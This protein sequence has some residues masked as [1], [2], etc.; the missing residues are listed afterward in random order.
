MSL[1]RRAP[2]RLASVAEVQ[3]SMEFALEVNLHSCLPLP[4]I[5]SYLNLAEMCELTGKHHLNLKKCKYIFLTFFVLFI[6]QQ[7]RRCSLLE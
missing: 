7:V 4:L 1:S 6:R 3:A 5:D 2:M